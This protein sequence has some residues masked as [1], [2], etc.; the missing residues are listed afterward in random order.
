MSGSAFG[1]GKEALEF[2]VHLEERKLVRPDFRN[3]D[4]IDGG[5]ERVLTL[6]KKFAQ[7]SFH[8]I[9]VHRLAEAT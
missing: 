4:E 7:Q 2:R 3:N 5:D 9:P 6:T 8:P 1:Q